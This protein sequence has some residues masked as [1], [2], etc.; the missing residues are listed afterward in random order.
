MLITGL[1]AKAS[2]VNSVVRSQTIKTVFLNLSWFT[3]PFKIFKSLKRWRNYNNLRN[4][5]DPWRLPG[6]KSFK[7]TRQTIN[8]FHIYPVYNIES[9]LVQS[10][11]HKIFKYK[12]F[13][14]SQK[15]FLWA[16]DFLMP[17]STKKQK[18]RAWRTWRT[19]EWYELEL[20]NLVQ[21]LNFSVLKDIDKS[22]TQHKVSKIRDKEMFIHPNSPLPFMTSV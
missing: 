12:L 1:K 16:S 11:S 20:R 21:N 17:G 10:K 8:Q 19:S 2:L 14:S 9:Q 5:L 4:L 6:W 7:S 15:L 3:T 13:L 18:R 22:F